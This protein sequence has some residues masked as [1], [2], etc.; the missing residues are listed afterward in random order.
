MK[1]LLAIDN[2]GE[3]FKSEPSLFNDWA[4]I[5]IYETQQQNDNDEDIKIILLSFYW[6]IYIPQFNDDYFENDS[7]GNVGMFDNS[8]FDNSNGVSLTRF[9]LS[10]TLN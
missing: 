5:I 9:W 1:F 8:Y 2:S 10:S 7:Q 4:S 6:H 3:F